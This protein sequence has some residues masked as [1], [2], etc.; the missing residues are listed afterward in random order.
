M[1]WWSYNLGGKWIDEG[2]HSDVGKGDSGPYFREKDEQLPE[3]GYTSPLNSS[4]NSK[5]PVECASG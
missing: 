5:N 4:P 1:M 3:K 2:G